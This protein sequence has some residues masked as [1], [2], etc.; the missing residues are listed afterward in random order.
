MNDLISQ[1]T[2]LDK[3]IVE[4]QRAG[5]ASAVTQIRS[6]MAEYSLSVADVL[7]PAEKRKMASGAGAAAVTVAAPAP[8]PAAP[9]K[10]GRKAKKADAPKAAKAE[11][12]SRAGKALGKVAIKFRNKETGDTW[13]GRGLKPRW[14]SA[15]LAAGKSLSDFAV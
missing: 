2:A 7:S 10:R 11:K 15:A 12:P 5:R 9:A 4:L 13:T 6:L 8:A 1:K 3:Q 14:L